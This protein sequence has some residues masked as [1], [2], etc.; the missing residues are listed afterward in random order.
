M[1]LISWCHAG[2]QTSVANS[3][4]WYCDT[5]MNF[6]HVTGC[7]ALTHNPD[8]YVAPDLSVLLWSPLD[9]LKMTWFCYLHHVTSL[10]IEIYG[11]DRRIWNKV[12]DFVL[13]K[14]LGAFKNYILSP[15]NEP[16][17]ILVTVISSSVLWNLNISYFFKN[18]SCCTLQNIKCFPMINGMFIE[19]HEWRSCW[20]R[21]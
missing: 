1:S 4:D 10:G 8:P 14:T 2:A 9:I 15:N 3:P 20:G 13:K 6:L 17:S 16:Y 12:S 11:T 7:R 18:L 19:F 21:F 5:P